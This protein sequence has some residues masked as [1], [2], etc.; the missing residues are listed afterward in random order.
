MALIACKECSNE[1]SDRAVTCP[2]CGAKLRKLRRGFFGGL[3][4][5]SFILFNILMMV[6]LFGAFSEVSKIDPGSDAGRV[7][8]AIG[9]A[10]GTSMIVG[11]WVAGSVILG[12][13]TLLTRP[14]P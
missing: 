9:T 5:Y 13:L 2:K 14:K 11:I 4:K 8:V 12:L 1:V 7:G 3:I 6:W 10:I